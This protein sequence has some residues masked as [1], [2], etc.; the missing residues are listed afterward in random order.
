MKTK[1]GKATSV[2]RGLGLSLAMNIIITA[3]VAAIIAVLLSR[4]II[5]WE[6]T[7]Y[8]IM[9]MLLTASF[10]GGKIA[11]SAIK[12]QRYL[13][14][15]M[16]GALYWMFLLCITALFFGGHYSSVLETGALILS[17]SIAA[18]LLNYPKKPTALRKRKYSYR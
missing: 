2:P 5:P 17:G 16:S 13:V 10:I 8:W 4:K 3:A 18:G 11:I 7:G 15:I 12:S 14:S 9:G 1:T 6:N